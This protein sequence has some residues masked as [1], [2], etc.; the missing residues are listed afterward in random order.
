VTYFVSSARPAPESPV[1]YN[2]VVGR[3]W[4]QES[5][6]TATGH[7]GIRARAL[8]KQGYRVSVSAL[9]P[10][11]TSVGRIKMSIVTIDCADKDAPEAP[12]LERL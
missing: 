7:A 8:R 11:V 6:D 12:I 3:T 2:R 9:G 4:V 5:Y 10:Q 1:C